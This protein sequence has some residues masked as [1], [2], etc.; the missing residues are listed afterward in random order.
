MGL[1]ILMK[2]IIPVV[3]VVRHSPANTT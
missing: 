3:F 1:F 2:E